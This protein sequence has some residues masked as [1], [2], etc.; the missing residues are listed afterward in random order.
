MNNCES[1]LGHW[2]GSNPRRSETGT[3][4]ATVK[5]MS[6]SGLHKTR[7]EQGEA[8]EDAFMGQRNSMM[9]TKSCF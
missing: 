7:V 9:W 8:V 4:V 6:G 5:H 1:C 3:P 2:Q